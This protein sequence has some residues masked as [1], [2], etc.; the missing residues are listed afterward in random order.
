MRVHRYLLYNGRSTGIARLKPISRLLVI[1]TIC[2]S[3]SSTEN[4]GNNAWDMPCSS[5]S[6]RSD[7]KNNGNCVRALAALDEDIKARWVEAYRDCCANKKSSHDCNGYRVGDWEM[8]LWNLIYDVEARTYQPRPSKAFIVTRPKIRE[9]F[10]ADFRD[11]IVQHWITLRINPLFEQRFA[12]QGDISHN[13]R[14]GHGTYA[15]VKAFEQDI[16]DVSND[17]ANEAWVCKIDVRSFFTSI[18]TDIMWRLLE[19]F[20][21]ANYKGKDID[22]LLYLTEITLRNRPTDNC[23][24]KSPQS[25]WGRLPKNKSMFYGPAG[26]GLAIG[27]ITSQLEA[28]FYMSFYVEEILPIVAEMGGR[29]E[30]YVD[31]IAFVGPTK[32]SCLRFRRESERILRDRLNLDLHPDKFYIQPARHG[33]KFVGTVIKPHRRYTSNR[34]VGEFI[35]ALRAAEKLCEEI[36]ASGPND[37]NLE[38]LYRCGLSL[39]SYLGSLV[40]NRSRNIIQRTLNSACKHF[41]RYCYIENMRVIKIKQ[42]YNYKYFITQKERINYGMVLHP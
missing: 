2:A 37:K 25:L 34:T 17:Y 38:R 14:K 18:D 26:K 31:D 16:C 23:L 6:L 40:H 36:T 28:N 9:V 22:T 1:P 4:N 12:S 39:N 3:A 21:R 19:P 5:G 8:D 30:Q 29:I 13:C 32:E 42:I 10:A 20:I 7:N 41:W 27:N 33:I 24:R 15:A 35:T 11:R